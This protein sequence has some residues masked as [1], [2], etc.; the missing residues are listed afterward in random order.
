MR[1]K[2]HNTIAS[3]RSFSPIVGACLGG[4]LLAG[5][6]ANT[7]IAQGADAGRLEKLEKENSDLKK[8]L[9][10]LEQKDGAV[11]GKAYT[12]KA[13]SDVTI[14]G[15]VTVS[16][17]YDTSVPADG[18]SN[19][20]LWNTSHNAFSINKIKLTLAS[21]PVERSGDTWDSAYRVSLMFGE[22]APIVNTGG[23]AQGFDEL[24]E[25][26][27]EL[28]A[29][30][31]NGLN[32]RAGQLI[33]L[34]NYESGDG[35]AANANFSQGYQWYYTGNGPSAGV[36]FGYTLSDMFDVKLRV[37]NGMY[38][39]PFDGN[40]AK[41]VMGA[42]GIKPDDK[43]WLSVVGFG[44]KENN[45]LAVYGAS[46]LG[47]RTIGDK[48]TTGIELDYFKFDGIAGGS[49]ADLYS[50]GVWLGYDFTAKVGVA[51]RAEYLDDP[52][53]GGINGVPLRG[54]ST[55]SPTGSLLSPDAD[56][57]ITSLALTLNYKPLPNV[58]IQP[59]VRFDNTTYKDGF[60]GQQN[61][62]LVGMGVTYLF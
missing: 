24:R 9:D 15:F 2:K 23:S 55:D 47:G 53:G 21:A 8:R 19:G 10:T 45:G 48:I 27:V 18:K 57:K 52:D 5:M 22:D 51:V 14:S 44:G 13:M 58:K 56:G 6:P 31:G 61:R 1:R 42:L 39:G 25:A 49:D 30:V 37:Q 7:V 54:S 46:L 62:F 33:S 12:V 60:D 40:S 38:A 35:G 17:F 34:L 29:P 28:N 50:A 16:Y 3:S 43:T 11:P 59:E 36:Q 4:A 20:Y 32:I 41:T 26:Y